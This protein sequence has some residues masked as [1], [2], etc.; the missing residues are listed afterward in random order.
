[1]R[2]VNLEVDGYGVWTGLRIERLAETLNV[3]HGPN[4]AGKTTLL[5]FIRSVLYGLSSERQRYLRSAHGGLTGGTLDVLSPHGPFRIS[6]HWAVRGTGLPPVQDRSTGFQ[7]VEDRGTGFQPVEDRGQDGL[8]AQAAEQLALSAPDGTRQGEHFVKVLLSNVDEATFNN[9]F[10]VGLREVQELATLSDTA[11]AE[12]LYSLSVGLDS[13]SLVEVLHELDAS[14]NRVLDVAGRPCQVTELL[15]EREKLRS[16]IEDLGSINHRYGQLAAER[17]RLQADLD[18]IEEESVR[19]QRLAELTEAALAVRELWGRRAALDEQL[20]SLSPL[21]A[22][23]PR[24]IERLDA[25]AARLQNHQRRIDGRAQQRAA[26]RKEY[27]ALPVDDALLRQAARIEALREQ[28]PW[29]TE[30]QAQVGELEKQCGGLESDLAAEA[31]QLGLGDCPGFRPGENGT[32]PPG[33]PSAPGTLRTLGRLA[34]RVREARRRWAEA[35]SAAAASASTAKALADEL[36]SALSAH[37]DRDLNAALDRAGTLVTQLRRRAQLDERLAELARHRAELEEQARH[38]AERE[39]LPMNVLV[40]LGAVFVVGVVLLSAGAV[41]PASIVGTAGWT[42]AA[43]GLACSAVAAVAKLTLE[44]R[45]HGQLAACEKRLELIRSQIPQAEEERRALDARLPSGALGGGL[46]A[47]EK[48]LSA[49]ESLSP[50][51]ARRAAAAQEVQSAQR[52]AE[53]A[54]PGLRAA[55]RRWRDSAAAAGLPETI[56][57]AAVRRLIE[58]SGHVLQL[59]RRLAENRQE[60]ARRRRDLQSITERIEQLAAE[61]GIGPGGSDRPGE[62]ETVSAGQVPGPIERLRALADAAARQQAAA[63]R[64]AAIRREARRLRALEARHEEAIGRLKH[65]RRALFL[66]AGVGSEQEFRQRALQAGRAEAL[67]GQRESVAAQIQ[68]ILGARCSEDAVRQQLQTATLV[69]LETRRSELRARGESLAGQLRGLLE[70]RG[71]LGE[72]LDALAADRRLASKELDLAV[73]E[74]RLEEAIRRWQ[75]LATTSAALDSIRSAYETHRQPEALQEASEYLKR[76]TQGRYVRVWAP[77]GEH[78]LRVDDAQGHAVPVELLSRGTR[79]QLFLSLRLAL[80]ASFARRGAPL[81]LVLDDVLVNFDAE[82]AK[83]AA[84]VLRD[85]AD[86]GHQLLVFTCHEH[87]MKLFQSLK[88]PVIHL[89]ANTE[90]ARIIVSED[91]PA[92]EEKP[93]ARRQRRAPRQGASEPSGPKRADLFA[94]PAEAPD[95]AERMQSASNDDDPGWDDADDQFGDAN[96]GAAAA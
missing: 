46:P 2:I 82:R 38:L 42:L 88:T 83:A 4:E 41:M 50:R 76:L 91:R 6:R 75:V 95:H 19:T 60:L 90:P 27:A 72:Q 44:H 32:V 30:V 16:E 78:A 35:K 12:M 43:I 87:M 56:G 33:L 64:R 45:N 79:E 77:L 17:G 36:Q 25:L 74:Q 59:Q 62:N 85:F 66:E 26:L 34:K 20:S 94:E 86:A 14:R 92:T 89:P 22:M 49:L 8:A 57:P 93:K 21:A 80:A 54:L 67:R 31:K 13:V 37:G 68:A 84:E 55:R 63:A 15:A 11:A 1:M 52:R 53:E 9:V 61:G 18:R 10:A 40:T 39:L 69:E 28:E 73:V 23:P 58:R 71:R 5:Q 3:F 51:E 7:P 29:I 24:S 70:Q 48:E 96:P 47:A 65:R 81:P